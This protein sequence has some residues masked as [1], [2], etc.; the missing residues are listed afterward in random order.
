[1]DQFDDIVQRIKEA[2]DIADVGVELG[3][4]FERESGKWRRVPHAG[5][6]VVNVGRQRFFSATDGVNGDVIELVRW[7]K[8]WEFRTTA[9]WLARRANIELPNWGRM[10]DAALKVHRLKVSVFEIAQ[11]V[12]HAWL[13]KDDEALAYLHGR[14]F[15]DETISAAGM[16]FSGRRSKEQAAEMKGQFDLFG[17]DIR[18]PLGVTI[19]GYEGDIKAWAEKWNVD[20]K[21]EDFNP[22]WVEKGRMH[23]M[24]ATPGIVYAHTWAGQV[25]YLSRRQL[26]GFDRIGDR[27]WKSF[28]PQAIF[29]GRRQAYFNSV[30]KGD[31]EQCVI[32]EG[33]ADAESFAMWG[34]SS[35]ALCGV[36]ADDEGMGNLRM[37][38]KRHK[39]VYVALDRDKAGDAKRERVAAVFGAKTRV[40]EFSDQLSVMH[41]TPSAVSDQKLSVGSEASDGEA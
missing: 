30:Y 14:G 12:F 35:V 24:M 4:K 28:N 41:S 29:A 7:K 13:W 3:L 34:I 2:N 31:A 5:G 40:V 17:I 21:D 37:R 36:N 1:M 38:L 32:V 27:D 16:G 18:S 39:K 15:M 22:D 8:G 26:P 9:E 25:I 19:F 11:Q 33:P 10:D 23:G 6:L 20:M